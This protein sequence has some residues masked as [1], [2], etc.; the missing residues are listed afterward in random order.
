MS[1]WS[2]VLWSVLR[3]T[4][5]AMRVMYVRGKGSVRV[6]SSVFVSTRRHMRSAPDYRRS[7]NYLD[8][9]LR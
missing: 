4:L 1:M 2:L 8:G 3:G 9:W 7:S 5:R 6:T